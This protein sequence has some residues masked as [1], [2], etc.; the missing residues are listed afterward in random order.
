MSAFVA[1]TDP[2]AA[3][4][5]WFARAQLSNAAADI[6]A[7]A[8]AS[9]DKVPAVRFVNYKGMYAGAFTFYT[10]Y[11]S[12]KGG[13]LALNPRA[14]LAFHWPQL[15]MQ[16]TAEGDCRPLPPDRSD[17]Y[18]ASR[19][20]EVQLTTCASRQSR[21]LDSFDTFERRIEALRIEYAEREIPRPP[22]W[23]G[24]MLTPSRIEFRIS[25]EH[26]RHRRWLY[27]RKTSGWAM[28]ELYP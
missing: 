28:S 4:E 3:F 14:A 5:Q 19:E 1:D 17:A 12:R 10:N 6:V 13:H 8:T 7:L 15:K 20:R 21:T 16:V 11:E 22:S 27:E 25:G 9:A 18:F 23:G 2:L 26:R 24:M